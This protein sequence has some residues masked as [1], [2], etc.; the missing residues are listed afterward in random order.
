MNN[1]TDELAKLHELTGAE[2]SRQVER[3]ALRNEFRPLE[4]ETDI[5]ISGGET[6]DDFD[7]PC[8]AKYGYRLQC[9]LSGKGFAYLFYNK[10]Q[11]F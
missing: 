4:G 5:Y 7:K 3:I 1:I 6:S 8:I 2:F 10:S 11:C 9:P